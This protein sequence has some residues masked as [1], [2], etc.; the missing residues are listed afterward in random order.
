M[1]QT[2]SHSHTHDSTNPIANPFP[3]K[4]GRDE[5]YYALALSAVFLTLA[6]AV[7]LS[8][9]L[10]AGTVRAAGGS[11]MQLAAGGV[12]VGVLG[13]KNYRKA[14]PARKPVDGW[15]E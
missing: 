3:R 15:E 14:F 8:A 2:P 10:S 6:G 1:S 5:P 11:V 4:P 9:R 7:A 13:M 12:L